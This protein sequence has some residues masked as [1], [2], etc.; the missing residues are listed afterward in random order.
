MKRTITMLG[1]LAF[2]ATPGAA[3]KLGKGGIG[4]DENTEVPRCTRPLGTIAVVEERA[5]GGTAEGIPPGLAALMRMAEA[6]NGGSQRVDPLPILKLLVSQSGCFQIVDRGEAFDALQR[7]RQ[8]AAGGAVAG[9]NNQ[10]T[11][12]AADYLLQAKVLYSDN[13]SG[14]SGGGLGSMFPGGLGFKQKVKASQTMLTLVEVKTGIQ[15][16]V[17]TGSARKKDLSILG[18]G[19]LTNTGIGALGGT[20]TSTDMGKIT[21]LA[22]LDAFI[23]LT[24]QAQSRLMPAGSVPA[25]PAPAVPG[26]AVAAPTAAPRQ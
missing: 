12:K 2:V 14:G 4:I 11:L 19:I 25:S 22:M 10:A 1:L 18:G 8:L 24:T 16:A 17:A 7:E 23:K 26:G 9:A 5:A 15:Q 21:S 6:Q 13:D 3:Q 20:Y